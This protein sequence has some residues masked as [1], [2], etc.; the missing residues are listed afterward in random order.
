M[1]NTQVIF[2]CIN[3]ELVIYN[4][5]MLLEAIFDVDRAN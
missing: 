4:K 2:M 1:R 3:I 5:V